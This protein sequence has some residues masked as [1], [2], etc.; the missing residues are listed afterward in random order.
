MLIERKSPVS[1][2]VHTLDID[3]TEDQLANWQHGMF[4]QEAMPN[5]SADEREF[6]MSGI[7]AEE[8]DTCF[9][10]IEEEQEQQE[11]QDC[12]YC[13]GTGEG[14]NDYSACK[15]CNGTGVEK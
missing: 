1:C 9:L 13:R 10:G 8:W 5:I 6:I 11:K 4:I 14:S 3:V 12:F 2:K 7:T 15:M